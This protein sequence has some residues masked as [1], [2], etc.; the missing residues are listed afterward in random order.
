[1]VLET[2]EV[3]KLRIEVQPMIGESQAFLLDVMRSMLVE[4]KRDNG[5]SE[6]G[7]ADGRLAVEESPEEAGPTAVRQSPAGAGPAAVREKISR[8]GN[9]RNFGETGHG[10]AAVPAE[11][12]PER[13]Q[14]DQPGRTDEMGAYPSGG[15][16][17]PG[18]SRQYRPRGDRQGC[19]RSTSRTF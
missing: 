4:V 14:S 8:D 18:I 13:D 15:R 12:A 19:A 2:F 6:S 16:T 3:E 11:V 10:E 9:L 1:M 5:W 7:S 17:E